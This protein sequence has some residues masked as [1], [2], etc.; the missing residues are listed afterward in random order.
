M[1]KE[2][3]EKYPP[4]AGGWRT[5]KTPAFAGRGRRLGEAWGAESFPVPSSALKLG[6]R[7]W[8]L[9]GS[10]QSFLWALSSLRARV[11]PLWPGGFLPRS[12]SLAVSLCLQ[13]AVALRMVSVPAGGGRGAPRCST[14][15]GLLCPGPSAAQSRRAGERTAAQQAISLAAFSARPISARSLDKAAGGGWFLQPF[16]GLGHRR[17]SSSSPAGREHL[18]TLGPGAPAAAAPGASILPASSARAGDGGE[19]AAHPEPYA[20]PAGR[21]SPSDA[22]FRWKYKVWA[23]AWKLLRPNSPGEAVGEGTGERGGRGRKGETCLNIAI[24]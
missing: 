20:A 21:P 7:A 23:P 17:T 12:C 6:A 19:P 9:D 10:G 8:G 22:G 18:A 24:K 1:S 14:A 3:K 16:L 15:S 11:R 4:S 2:D 5:G 13:R